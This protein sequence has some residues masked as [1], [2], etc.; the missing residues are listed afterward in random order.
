MNR[1]HHPC[2]GQFSEALVVNEDNQIGVIVSPP[3][4]FKDKIAMDNVFCVLC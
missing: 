4:F 3:Y 2:N 1:N